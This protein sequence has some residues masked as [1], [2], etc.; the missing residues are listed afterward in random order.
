MRNKFYFSAFSGRTPKKK[1]KREL[2]VGNRRVKIKI[3][4]K[5]PYQI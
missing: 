2:N 4:E 3:N 5:Y 1:V